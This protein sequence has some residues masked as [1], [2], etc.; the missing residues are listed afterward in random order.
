MSQITVAGTR[1]IEQ[2]RARLAL[3]QCDWEALLREIRPWL[4]EEPGGLAPVDAGPLAALLEVIGTILHDRL[5][6]GLAWESGTWRDELIKQR[7]RIDQ[8]WK[9]WS[10]AAEDGHNCTLRCSEADQR[11]AWALRPYLRQLRTHYKARRSRTVHAHWAFSLCQRYAAL[12]EDE[13]TA[14]AAATTFA[15]TNRAAFAAL[16]DAGEFAVGVLVRL[17]DE[18]DNLECWHFHGGKEAA[19]EDAA[20]DECMRRIEAEAGEA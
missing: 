9:V 11:L 8:W 7:G 14:A 6:Q 19:E 20:H 13:V 3:D 1:T 16:L 10:H 2:R 4:A 15:T 12:R 18:A 5:R 17:Q